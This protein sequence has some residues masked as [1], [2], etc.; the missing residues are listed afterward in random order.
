MFSPQLVVRFEEVTER[1]GGAA[2]WRKRADE[3]VTRQLPVSCPRP[4]LLCATVD[5]GP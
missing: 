1:L 2:P 5:S 3:N 4:M